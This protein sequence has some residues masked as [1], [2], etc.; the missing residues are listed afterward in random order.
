MKISQCI[1]KKKNIKNFIFVKHFCSISKS[2]FMMYGADATS[3]PAHIFVKGGRRYSK[4]IKLLW[5]RGWYGRCVYADYLLKLRYTSM[6][7]L[8]YSMRM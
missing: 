7:L 1:K 6:L 3:S 8:Y 2:V 4:I 5:G